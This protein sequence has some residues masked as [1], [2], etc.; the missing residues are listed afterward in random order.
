[1]WRV[2]APKQANAHDFFMH[3]ILAFAALH[4]AYQQ[5]QDQ[6]QPYYACGI[7]HQDL[8][9]RGVREKLQNVTDEDAPAIVATSTLL[10]FSVFASTGFEAQT[11][12]TAPV[13]DIDSLV[14]AFHLMQ[15][16]GHVLALA[17]M[18]VRDS[19]LGPILRDPLEPTASQPVLL[20]LK[21]QLPALVTFIEGR[22]DLSEAE[23]QLYLTVIHLFEPAFQISLPARVDNRELRF[24]FFWPL[25]LG[26]DFMEA[27]QQRRS[28]AIVILLYYTTMFH[29]AETRYWFMEGWGQRVSKACHQAID[30]SWATAIVWPLSFLEQGDSW[31]LFTNVLNQGQ[32][33]GSASASQQPSAETTPQREAPTIGSATSGAEPSQSYSIQRRGS[34]F[35]VQ[36][37]AAED[38]QV[39]GE[40]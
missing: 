37:G 8:A 31:S 4:K 18:A 20:E 39:P 28:G 7:H 3:E 14:N 32:A 10:T 26:P 27:I 35:A 2:E 19:F 13:N 16:M 34:K 17:Q 24:L 30:Q 9:I 29:A 6:R 40:D 36:M 38:E 25:Q 23:R 12:L 11:P 15:G 33:S 1:M 21:S 5:P 22:T